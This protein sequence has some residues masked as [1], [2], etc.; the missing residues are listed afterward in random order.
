MYCDLHPECIRYNFIEKDYKGITQP[1]QCHLHG[2]NISA[3][4][5]NSNHKERTW[6]N[7]EFYQLNEKE[8]VSRQAVF[9]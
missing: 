8:N 5:Y 7:L 6:K 2:P 3:D 9:L 1:A 4:K